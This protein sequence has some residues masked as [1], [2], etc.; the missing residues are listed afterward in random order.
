[1]SPLP[2]R[3]E[4]VAFRQPHQPEPDVLEAARHPEP[5]RGGEQLAK[6]ELLPLVG[7]DQ[8]ARRMPA[9]DAIEHARHVGGAVVESAVGLAHHER[10]QRLAV[11]LLGEEDHHRALARLGDLLPFEP[12]DGVGEPIVVKALAEDHVE[13]DPEPAIDRL[14]LGHRHRDELLPQRDVFGIALLQLDQLV[15][16]RFQDRR[17]LF[18]SAASPSSST[19]PPASRSS[20][21]V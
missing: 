7:D 20:S 12:R 4:M 1:M 5:A 10:R 13:A 19:R 11:A 16:R 2:L 18:P 3:V 15:A 14:E 8:N 6:M 21:S 17:R 9:L